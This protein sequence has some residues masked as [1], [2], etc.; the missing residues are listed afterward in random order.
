MRS[1]I[2]TS[3]ASLFASLAVAQTELEIELYPEFAK[4]MLH[5]GYKWEA[6]TLTTDDSYKLTT[7][8]ITER[9]GHEV[10]PDP[11]LNPVVLMHGLGCDATSWV[12]PSWEPFDLPL[13]LL[14]F[15]RGFDVYLASNRGTK[16]CQG[17]ESLAVDDPAFWDFSWVEMGLYDDVTNVK[18]IK[19]RTGKK[20]SYVGVSQGTVQMFYALAKLE[21]DFFA[22]HLFT[23]AALDPC[24]IDITEGDDIYK[25]GL[26]HFHEYGIYAF[27]GPNWDS[28]LQT[29]CDNFDQEICDY[30][31]GCAGG[32]P[33][34]L[35]TN[36]HWA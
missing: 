31:T 2:V 20:V 22:E 34:S 30:A 13:P 11:D 7:F 36:V 23:F 19:E 14:L 15:N 21:A 5:W 35:K 25:D 17:H 4:D 8:R 12:D 18:F 24:T 9:K 29:I 26:F 1:S 32:E 28:D 27:G 16:Y 6:F 10:V 3:L 33:V